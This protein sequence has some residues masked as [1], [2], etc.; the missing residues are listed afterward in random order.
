MQQSK[1]KKTFTEISDYCK[2]DGRLVNIFNNL[3]QDFDLRYINSLFSAVK[4]QGVNASDVFRSLFLLKFINFDN[5]HQLMQ[6]GISKELSHKK[7]VFYDFLNN[8]KI[9]WRNILW[10]FTKQALKLISNKSIDE[11]NIHPKCLVVDDSILPKTGKTIELIGKVFDHGTHAYKL[12]MKL[13]TLGYN[14][15][16][17]FTPLDFSLHHEPTK[18]KNRGMKAKDLNKQYS[19]ERPQDTPG[20][21]REK[22]ISESKIDIAINM[23]IRILKRNIKVDYVLADSWFISEDFIKS[24]VAFNKSVNVIGLL[25][26]NRIL[27]INGKKLNANKVADVYRKNIRYCK[28]L[29]CHYIKKKV[30]YKGIELVGF[31]VKMQGQENWKLLITTDTNLSF[32]KAM[33]IYQ[34]RWSIEVFFKDC[35]QSLKLNSCQSKDLD[36]HIATISLIFMNY[37][38]LSMKRRFEDYETLGIL[39]K[40]CKDLI[41]EQTLIERIW[42]LFEKILNSLLIDLGVD[43]DKVMT[44]LIENYDGFIDQCNKS[45]ETLFAFDIKR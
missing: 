25:K 36:A 29:K 26:M 23:I 30:S 38:V 34:I 17:S 16:K 3:L 22:E 9:N 6:S 7:D 27:N 31:W 37:T 14:D 4:K 10:L 1:N 45:F 8:P 41:L 12:G 21:E 18:K 32:I 40:R 28:S 19:K 20:Y 42:N 24:I 33:K 35:K 39:F 15:G 5:V 2:N 11:D 43:L 44:K 13:L